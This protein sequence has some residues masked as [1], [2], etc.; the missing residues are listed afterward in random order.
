MSTFDSVLKDLVFGFSSKA[1]SIILVASS[2]SNGFGRYSNAPP[3]NDSTAA[4]MSENAVITITGRSSKLLLIC[5][6]R[7]YPNIPGI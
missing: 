2:R 5:L 3:P 1:L 6:R 7:S 4:C